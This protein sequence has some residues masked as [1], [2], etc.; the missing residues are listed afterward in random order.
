MNN[1]VSFDS[2]LAKF[3]IGL[4]ETIKVYQGKSLFLRE[5][6]DRLYNS[7]DKLNI[8]IVITKEKLK[9]E[10]IEYVKELDY[11]AFRVT[12]FSDGYNFALREIPYKE[13]D[14]EKGYKLK[15]APLKRGYSPLYFHKHVNYFENIYA[16]RQVLKKGYDEALFINMD[17]KV[18]EGSM[19]NIFFIK[20][21]KII[22]P[23]KEIGLLP[24]IIRQKVIEIADNLK[25]DLI[26]KEIDLKEL[27][28]FDFPFITNSLMDLMPVKEI[29]EIKYKKESDIFKQINNNFKDMAYRKERKGYLW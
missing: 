26:E 25:L 13:K 2:E 29:E 22:T 8:P 11:K 28:E 20:G 21:N 18:M 19:S 9:K 6:L 10:I 7:L 5:H 17:N 15:I 27:K 24:G 4:F 1:K 16:K 3:G 12:V 23:K 14:Y